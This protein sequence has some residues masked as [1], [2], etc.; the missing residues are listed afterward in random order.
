MNDEDDDDAR[1][2][3]QKNWL[4]YI[5]TAENYNDASYSHGNLTSKNNK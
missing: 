1:P 2:K 5:L 3:F 4:K